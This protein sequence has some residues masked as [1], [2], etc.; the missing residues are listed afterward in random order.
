MSL[1]EC[2]RK[3]QIDLETTPSTR[4][5]PNS[6]YPLPNI[7][8]SYDMPVSIGWLLRDEGALASGFYLSH[9]KN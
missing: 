7:P 8:K 5:V 2:F 1:G 3:L 4:G 9:N 6:F